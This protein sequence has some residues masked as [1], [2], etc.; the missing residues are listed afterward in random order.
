[1]AENII[2]NM[3]RT[4]QTVFS[5]KEL[6]MLWPNESQKSLKS[7]I[8]YYIQNGEIYHIRRGLYA[9]DKN[10]NRSEL[11]TKIFTPSY[12][13]FE[14]VL[15]SAGITFQYYNQIFVA[16]YQTR[17]VFCDGQQYSFKRLK[18][19]ILTNGLGVEIKETYSIA[20]PERA[21]LD[22]LY[23]NKNYHFDNLAP[24]NWDN[25]YEILPFYENKRMN[26]M[27]AKFHKSVKNN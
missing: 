9:K 10:Y 25:V 2:K 1:M 8:N 17:N 21:F 13:S 4:E 18:S 26:A 16:T 22:V 12:V 3:L 20:T 6:L 24:L 11:A 14:T 19:A 5:F 23:L 7:K 15:G 27:V